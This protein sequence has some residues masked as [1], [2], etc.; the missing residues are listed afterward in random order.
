MFASLHPIF[1]LSYTLCVVTEF[2]CPRFFFPPRTLVGMLS[3]S[4]FLFRPSLPFCF[5]SH[6]NRIEIKTRVRT[7]R[8]MGRQRCYSFIF[9]YFHERVCLCFLVC[10]CVNLRFPLLPFF[11]RCA[12]CVIGGIE[13]L[14]SLL[15]SHEP[16]LVVFL[17]VYEEINA[18]PIALFALNFG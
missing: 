13:R 5:L 12:P 1:S 8:V 4:A 7:Y 9:Q 18:Y 16:R 2:L 3:L 6:L 11:R 10:A 15:V 17:S 14:V